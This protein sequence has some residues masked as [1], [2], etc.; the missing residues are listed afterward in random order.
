M[1]TQQQ[2]ADTTAPLP[3]SATPMDH[4][5]ATTDATATPPAMPGSADEP[6]PRRDRN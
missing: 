1:K 6:K 3:S 5:A 2:P 4:S